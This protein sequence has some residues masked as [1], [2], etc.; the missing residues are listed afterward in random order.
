MAK[1]KTEVELL[2]E[3]IRKGNG[4]AYYNLGYIYLLGQG[5]EVDAKK[6]VE[7]FRKGTTHQDTKCMQ[8]LAMCYKHGDGVEKDPTKVVYWLKQGVK[9]N[10]EGC[11]YQLALCYESGLGVEE[12]MDEAAA[13]MNQCAK[14]NKDARVWLKQ[15]GYAKPSLMDR[16]FGGF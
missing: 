10:D 8:G 4:Q 5:V 9:L 1:K 13:L 14:K 7:Y 15:H 2:E 6:A 11:M 16:L 3:E 12:N